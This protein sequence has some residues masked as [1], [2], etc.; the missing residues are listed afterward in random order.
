MFSFSTPP[1]FAV[2]ALFWRLWNAVIY[3][4]FVGVGLHAVGQHALL[5]ALG[6]LHTRHQPVDKHGNVA[7]V[8]CRRVAVARFE[9]ARSGV[10]TSWQLRPGLGYPY[11]KQ[12]GSLIF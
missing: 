2:V 3:V 11:L 9:S 1:V 12:L 5:D 7:M 4:G 6:L 10:A 8:I